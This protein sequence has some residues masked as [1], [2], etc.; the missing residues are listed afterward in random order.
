M[1]ILQPNLL[2]LLDSVKVYGVSLHCSSLI[3]RAQITEQN[4]HEQN[5][6]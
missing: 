5:R 3:V 1:P 4:S 6:N 2:L